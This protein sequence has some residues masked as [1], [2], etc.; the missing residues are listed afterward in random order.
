MNLS[1]L[2]KEGKL[3]QIESNALRA[4]ECLTAAE[5]D[6]RA[7][8]GQKDADWSFSIAYNAMLHAARA[9]M[10][11]DGYAPL[12]EERHKTAVAYADAKL[13][14]K[15][16]DL[17]NLFDKMRAK[18]HLVMY[19]TSGVISDY[20]AKFAIKSAEEFLQKV[21]EKIKA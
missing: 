12:G 2:L 7:A 17:I 19:E 20:E 21:R 6:I 11:S 13:G 18:R 14:A 3:K 1:D 16:R 4:R 9:L 10:F 5:K 15:Y 8:K